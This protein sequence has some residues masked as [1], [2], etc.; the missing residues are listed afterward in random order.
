MSPV[1]EKKRRKGKERKPGEE[2]RETKKGRNEYSLFVGSGTTGCI[3]LMY[4]LFHSFFFAF[5]S[6]NIIFMHYVMQ[7]D[8]LHFVNNIK[9]N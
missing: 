3:R 6:T 2:E 1:Y 9:N 4:V 7:I 8:L 5:F